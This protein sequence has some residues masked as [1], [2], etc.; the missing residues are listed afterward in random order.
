MTAVQRRRRTGLSLSLWLLAFWVAGTERAVPGTWC[1]VHAQTV[2]QIADRVA[3][4]AAAN[5]RGSEP[6]PI[7]ELDPSWPKPL[8]NNWRLGYPNGVAVD[9]RDHIWLINNNVGHLEDIEQAG[10]NPA[11]PVLQFD[12]E[13]NLLQAWGEAGQGGWAQGEGRPFPSAAIN[14]DWEGNVWVGE[15]RRG[16][17]VVKFTPDGKFLMQ[18]GEVDQTNGSADTTLLGWPAEVNFDPEA[19][20]VY[21]ADGYLNRRI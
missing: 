8:P 21:I 7:F 9:S 3:E 4:T 11:P 17:A 13:G 18:I 12:Q 19:N 10:K 1:V 16:H 15:E 2:E 20:E 6:A 5:L 14:I